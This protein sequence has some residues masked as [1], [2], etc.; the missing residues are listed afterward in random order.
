MIDWTLD[1]G[2]LLGGVWLAV[3]VLYDGSIEDAVKLT[4]LTACVYV[5]HE[6]W[7][8]GRIGGNTHVAVEDAIRS[9]VSMIPPLQLASVALGTLALIIALTT[10]GRWP[11]LWRFRRTVLPRIADLRVETD[12]YDDVIPEKT[13]LPLQD[14][15]HVGI[16]DDTPTTVRSRLRQHDDVMGAPLASIQYDMVNGQRVYE[17]GSFAVRPNGMF[18]TWQY[19]IRLTPRHGGTHTSLWAHKEYNPWSHPRKHYRAESWSAEKGV[20]YYR[21]RAQELFGQEVRV[22]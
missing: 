17:V 5:P 20:R 19:H 7:E 15:E 6:A 16:V 22:D 4:L 14:R 9:S 8:A 2:A 10:F 13:R 1:G 12:E 11:D 21:D 3:W 18:S